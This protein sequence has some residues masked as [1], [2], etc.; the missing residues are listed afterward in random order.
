LSNRVSPFRLFF[1]TVKQERTVC[2]LSGTYLCAVQGRA[3]NLTRGH[4]EKA[5]C[6]GVPY[7]LLEIEASRRKWKQVSVQISL[8]TNV[9]C[10]NL[11]FEDFTECFRGPL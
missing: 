8:S 4:F 1:S 5:A 6:S 2:F 11:R 3:I 10:D 7:L 9:Y